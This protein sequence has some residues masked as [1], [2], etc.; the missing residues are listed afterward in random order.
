MAADS[1]HTVCVGFMVKCVSSIAVSVTG[2][3]IHEEGVM[4]ESGGKG[5]QR[6]IWLRERALNHFF[7]CSFHTRPPLLCSTLI[8]NTQLHSCCTHRGIVC[9]GQTERR[10]QRQTSTHPTH[11]HKHT[12]ICTIDRKRRGYT[13]LNS[14]ATED[15]KTKQNTAPLYDWRGMETTPCLER[16]LH[17]LMLFTLTR[18][19]SDH[20]L[21]SVQPNEKLAKK[22]M[23]ATN[24]IY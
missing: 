22:W 14:S 9:W 12:Q 2:L 11:T 20:D 21:T 4:A 3:I 19:Q 6:W 7:L 10:A 18:D 13:Y 1:F 23:P 17:Y 8:C 24:C 15:N 16:L 5:I